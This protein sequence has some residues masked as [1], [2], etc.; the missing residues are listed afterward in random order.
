M[1]HTVNFR[2]Y[3]TSFKTKKHRLNPP[4][5][6]GIFENTHEA[7]ISPGE[8]ETAQK[9][10]KVKRRLKKSDGEANPLTGLVY[11]ADCSSR[12]YNHRGTRNSEPRP[13]QDSYC[14]TNTPNTRRNP[15]QHQRQVAAGVDSDGDT[16]RQ[17]VRPGTRSGVCGKA[18]VSHQQAGSDCNA[19]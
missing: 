3:K 4:E 9:C 8:W 19:G 2:T 6:W 18:G 10:R 12:M 7:L 14:C 17:R 13:S 15:A 11:C 5:K 1:G 16:E